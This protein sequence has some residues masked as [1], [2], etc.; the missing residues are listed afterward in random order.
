MKLF[1]FNYFQIV[2]EMLIV[3]T[4]RSKL[5]PLLS[6]FAKTKLKY[7]RIFSVY[8]LNLHLIGAHRCFLL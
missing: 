3:K 8:F 5:I 2:C 1:H 4:K 6:K 7:T